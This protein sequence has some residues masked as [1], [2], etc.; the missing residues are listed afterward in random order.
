MVNQMTGIEPDI[1]TL[2]RQQSGRPQSL[3]PVMQREGIFERT[4]P[5]DKKQTQVDHSPGSKEV[6]IVPLLF[7][8][9]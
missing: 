9:K 2:L 5:T 4:H 3:R 8:I 6:S 1:Q 7:Q